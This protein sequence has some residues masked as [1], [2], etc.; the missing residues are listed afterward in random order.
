MAVRSREITADS[1]NI[2]LPERL[3]RRL[4][5]NTVGFIMLKSRRPGFVTIDFE[6]IVPKVIRTGGWL[7]VEPDDKFPLNW[8][9]RQTT[10]PEQ[11]NYV[12]TVL[13]AGVHA[14]LEGTDSPRALRLVV[15]R[16]MLLPSCRTPC[17]RRSYRRRSRLG[18][19]TRSKALDP[20]A[21]FYGRPRLVRAGRRYARIGHFAHYLDFYAVEHE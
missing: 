3:T 19:K 16:G 17:V 15:T 9:L 20:S 10:D 8:S 2:D 11:P 4:D 6:I 5:S 21:D 7:D 13:P 1:V 14:T 18:G 12:G